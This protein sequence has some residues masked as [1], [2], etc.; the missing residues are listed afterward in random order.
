MSE[1]VPCP[2]CDFEAKSDFGLQAH[3]RSKHGPDAPAPAP[4]VS[5]EPS[6]APDGG[7][8]RFRCKRY[9]KLVLAPAGR[10]VGQFEN[11]ELVTDNPAAIALCESLEYVEALT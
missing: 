10:V 5:A 3:S 9:P 2:D 7:T 1:S 11:R 8:R 4:P 6:P